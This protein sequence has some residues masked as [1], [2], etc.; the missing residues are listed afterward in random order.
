MH[1]ACALFCRFLADVRCAAC[2]KLTDCWNVKKLIYQAFCDR[3]MTTNLLSASSSWYASRICDSLSSGLLCYGGSNSLFIYDV[4]G[5][6]PKYQ[7]HFAAHT[8]RLTS[9]ALCRNRETLFSCS[10]GED[11]KIRVHNLETKKLVYEHV[12]HKVWIIE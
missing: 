7:T 11:G 8:S 12:K 4:S 3:T 9:V 5:Q 10:S 6:V 2:E 1:R